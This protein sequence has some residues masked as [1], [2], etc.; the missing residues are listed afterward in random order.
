M[1]PIIK[2]D[3]QEFAETAEAFGTIY[4]DGEIWAYSPRI[5]TSYY[6]SCEKFIF[7]YMTLHVPGME[8][9]DVTVGTFMNAVEWI[10]E[11][12]YEK[13]KSQGF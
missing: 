7:Q 4:G 8:E 11:E 2:M 5:Y 10:S 3:D 13:L 9:G 6:S 1:N 12:E